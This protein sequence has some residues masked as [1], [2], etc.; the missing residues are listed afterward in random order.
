MQQKIWRIDCIL[1]YHVS[2]PEWI[3][4]LYLPECQGNPYS[5]QA[6]YLKLKWQASLAKWLSLRTKWF[7]VGFS[8]LSFNTYFFH[9]IRHTW[10][11]TLIRTFD[12]SS[13][14]VKD[15]IEWLSF[16]LKKSVVFC[17]LHLLQ[18][19]YN[20]KKLNFWQATF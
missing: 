3:Y 8:L 9:I 1:S 13:D 11:A 20:V 4:T 17:R 6:R 10:F 12:L 16:N 19:D 5:K 2:V 14:T 15:V 7:W 18:E